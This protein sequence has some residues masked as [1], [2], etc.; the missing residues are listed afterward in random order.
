MDRVG[1]GEKAIVGGPHQVACCEASGAPM[2]ATQRGAPQV[3]GRAVL[4]KQPQHL[5]LVRY[6]VHGELQRDQP[7]H[8]ANPPATGRLESRRDVRRIVARIRQRDQ[9]GRMALGRER[10]A[11]TLREDLGAAADERHR[12]VEDG[13]SHAINRHAA[14]AGSVPVS[15]AEAFS[16]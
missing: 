6:E 1:L 9:L 3:V 11:Q 15:S 12:G 14:A 16:P 5:V 13:D 10:R 4:M 2:H 8:V 7:I